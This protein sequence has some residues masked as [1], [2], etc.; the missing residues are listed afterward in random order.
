MEESMAPER[1][2]IQVDEKVL[3][4]LKARLD[5]TRWPNPWAGDAWEGG[6]DLEAL[7][8]LANHWRTRFDWRV[9]EAALNRLAQYRCKIGGI[10]VHFVHERGVGPEPLP[11]ILTHGWPDSFLRYQKVIP[12]LTDP[13]AHGGDPADAF[14]VVVPSVPGFGFSSRPEQGGINNQSISE[15][16]ATLMTEILGYHRFAAGGG[17]VGSGVTRYLASGHPDRLVGIHLT[18][19]GIVRDLV[20]A[21]NPAL[22]SEAERDYQREAQSWIAREGAY[23]AIQSTRPQT[24]AFGLTDSPVGLAAWILDKFRS[25]SDCQ[26]NLANRFTADELLTNI[27]LYWFA[28]NFGSSARLYYENVRSLPP[29]PRIEVPTGMALFSADILLPPRDW[30]ERHFRIERWTK[31]PRGGHFTAWE[32]PELWVEDIRAFFRPLRRH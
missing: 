1:F 31:L 13:A 9:Q 19:I 25:W 18:D 6:T 14:D 4:D 7:R 24:L 2:H 11:I 27:M 15:L 5:H 23:M 10:D 12:L 22:L 30:A 20:N 3:E 17:D 21:P 28:G 16:W 32:E 26:G 29:L 8:G